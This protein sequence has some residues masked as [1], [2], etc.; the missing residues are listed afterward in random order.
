MRRQGN[1]KQGPLHQRGEPVKPV[2]LGEIENAAEV[3]ALRESN[4]A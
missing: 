2:S 3:V 1:K 4:A